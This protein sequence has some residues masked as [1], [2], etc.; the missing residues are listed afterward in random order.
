MNLL[1]IAAAV[2]VAGAALVVLRPAGWSTASAQQPVAAAPAPD[3][4][5]ADRWYNSPPLTI[6]ALRGKVVLVEFWTR[7]CINCIHVLPH[8]KALYDA[9]GKDGLMVIGVHT[10]EY[11]EERDPA[12]LQE[13]LHRYGIT[14]PVAVDNDSRIWNAYQN[15][16][17]PAIYLVDKSGRV[18]YRH[19]GEGD[20]DGTER[21]IRELLGKA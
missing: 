1:R 3:F 2:A 4:T 19:Y 18:V 12:A 13:A 14:W 11:D 21:R 5:G 9:Y 16:Y 15:R 7:E 10:P 8:T 6:D 20:Y 17:W